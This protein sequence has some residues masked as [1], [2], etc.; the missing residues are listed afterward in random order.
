MAADAGFRVIVPYTG[1][2]LDQVTGLAQ[3][4]MFSRNPDHARFTGLFIGGRDAGLALDM[5][6]AARKAM[7]PPFSFSVFAD[8]SGAFTTAAALVAVVERALRRSGR[9]GLN[10][11]SVLV[12]GATGVVG[13]VAGVIAAQVGARVT[14]VSYRG[15]APVEAKAAEFKARFGVVMAA[16]DAPD[17][18]AK[19]ALLPGADVVL[20][21][22]RAGVQVLGPQHL[23]HA[24]RLLVAADINAVP[25]AGIEGIGAMDD[26]SPLTGAPPSGSPAGAIGAIAVGGVK[27]QVQHRLLRE[28]TAGAEPRAF[29]VEDAYRIARDVAM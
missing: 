8:P 14:L 12:F 9:A 15:L 7:F 13:S 21:C 23:A 19:N 22:G 16:A 11:L 17:D 5:L 1:I 24:G 27:F 4:A 29:G 20:C 26:G 10:G 25:P 28:M 3:D 2:T 18:R 6:D